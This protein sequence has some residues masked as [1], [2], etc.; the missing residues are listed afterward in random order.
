MN[1]CEVD[2]FDEGV[3]A[4]TLKY[5]VDIISIMATKEFFVCSKCQRRK[6]DDPELSGAI[7]YNLTFLIR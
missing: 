3:V 5:P 7:E 6:C 4:C 1:K 2:G